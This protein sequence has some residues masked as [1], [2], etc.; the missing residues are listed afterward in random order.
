MKIK[1]LVYKK[2]WE[3]KKMNAKT[4]DRKEKQL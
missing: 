1:I 4:T 3:E 2:I